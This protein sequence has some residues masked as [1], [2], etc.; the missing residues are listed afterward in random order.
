MHN[1]EL[2]E[3]AAELINNNEDI[4]R[5]IVSFITLVDLNDHDDAVRWQVLEKTYHDTTGTANAWRATLAALREDLNG[6]P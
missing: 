2:M 1:E 5:F 3:L 6:A 4:W